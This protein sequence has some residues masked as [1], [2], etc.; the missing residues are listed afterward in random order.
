MSTIL[1]SL[2]QIGNVALSGFWMPLFV[3]TAGAFPVYLLLCSTERIEPDIRYSTLRALLLALP[4][5]YV[6]I[7]L[8]RV[9]PWSGFETSFDY[10]FVLADT[11]LPPTIDRAVGV[12]SGD[13]QPGLLHI[14]GML[15]IGAL[16]V[17]VTRLTYVLL[18]SRKLSTL[19]KAFRPIADHTVLARTAALASSLGISRGVT[20]LEGP[21]DTIPFTFGHRRPSI[22]IP[23]SLLGEAAT[24]AVV[25]EHELVH[26]RRS[27]YRSGWIEQIVASIFAIHPL[28][29][30]L[31]RRIA[32]LR[33]LCC[34]AAVLKR[35]T[36]SPRNYAQIILLF[37]ARGTPSR[38]SSVPMIVHPTSNLKTRIAAM[39]NHSYGSPRGRRWMI[40]T[41]ALVVP[42]FMAACSTGADSDTSV[43]PKQVHSGFDLE[44][45]AGDLARLEVQIEYLTE[46]LDDLRP[47]LEAASR[48]GENLE[49]MPEYR[50]F[51]LLQ[52]LY[53][54]RLGAYETMKM[55]QETD[56]RL[57]I[58]AP[59]T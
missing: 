10:T 25:L 47:R 9:V 35:R 30:R 44:T 54:Q 26:V 15:S 23:R 17:G 40:A 14:V 29:I 8:V 31:Q 56:R 48:N 21:D 22:V 3:W 41:L 5:A 24:L 53:M 4:L 45:S 52:E 11:S 51:R 18:Q 37:G 12:P 16:M 39:N 59:G 27:D 36:V 32:D 49:M 6:L 43:P 20:L 38:A 42:A 34:D 28:A 46:E 33:E 13:V 55:E 50:R 19:R 57:G 2:Q 1:E 58:V 7:P